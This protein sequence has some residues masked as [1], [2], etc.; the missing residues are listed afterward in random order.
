MTIALV[1][2]AIVVV[3][4]FDRSAF[5]GW[6]WGEEDAL[7][8]IGGGRSRSGT[9]GGHAEPRVD[10]DDDLFAWPGSVSQSSR[11]HADKTGGQGRE[12]TT[13]TRVEHDDNSEGDERPLSMPRTPAPVAPP[14]SH[15]HPPHESAEELST[16]VG[17]R[18]PN[19]SSVSFFDPQRVWEYMQAS[20]PPPSSPPRPPFYDSNSGYEEQASSRAMRVPRVR[21]IMGPDRV[22]DR[23]ARRVERLHGG[24]RELR[25]IY[26]LG[27]EAG[28]PFGNEYGEAQGVGL[29]QRIG[30][31][32]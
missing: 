4:T 30:G 23:G 14:P 25:E 13:Q 16:A 26:G 20:S 27:Y 22:D 21:E 11:S 1:F 18:V 12:T 7:G 9:F 6:L 32:Q 31:A 10:M 19:S 3:M 2:V 5:R 15:P 8:A 28:A 24:K 29:W 17:P